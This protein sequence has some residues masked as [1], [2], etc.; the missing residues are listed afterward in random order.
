MSGQLELASGGGV[1][2]LEI[3][4]PKALRND[5]PWYHCPILPSAKAAAG[6]LKDQKRKTLK[7]HASSRK[8]PCSKSGDIASGWLKLQQAAASNVFSRCFVGIITP[9]KPLRPCPAQ[10][11]PPPSN[12]LIGNCW[13]GNGWLSDIVLVRVFMLRL[14]GHQPRIDASLCCTIQNCTCNYTRNDP[15]R[16]WNV[17][18]TWAEPSIW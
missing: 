12:K 11:S 1:L 9:T 16:S 6:S 5:C 8:A 3:G 15:T 17:R 7:S 13:Q 10:S 2:V 4:L 18:N 14:M